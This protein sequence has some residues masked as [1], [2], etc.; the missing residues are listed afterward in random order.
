MGGGQ[1]ILSMRCIANQRNVVYQS[2]YALAAINGAENVFIACKTTGLLHYESSR[3]P[4]MRKLRKEM[5]G[6]GG[7]QTVVSKRCVT[8][9]RNVV[10]QPNNALK[11]INGPGHDITWL[12]RNPEI[13]DHFFDKVREIRFK[14]RFFFLLAQR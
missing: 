2:S 3:G 9:Q 8:N 10:Y 7:G 11:A 13:R 6:V 5:T 4:I 1:T 12:L 14:S